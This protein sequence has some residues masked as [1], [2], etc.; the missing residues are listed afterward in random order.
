M[1]KYTARVE[2]SDDSEG[3]RKY[4]AVC[5]CGFASI[6]WDK[7]KHADERMAQ[8]LEEHASGEPMEEL[9]DFRTRNGI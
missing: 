6:G 1:P 3:N 4:D 2:N 7:K 8:H 9:A 5:T